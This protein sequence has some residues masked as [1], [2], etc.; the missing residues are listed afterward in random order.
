MKKC[1][2]CNNPKLDNSTRCVDCEEKLHKAM[3]D[4]QEKELENP[5]H[6]GNIAYGFDTLTGKVIAISEKGFELI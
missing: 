3:F 1:T 5:A 4:H 6:T 2:N